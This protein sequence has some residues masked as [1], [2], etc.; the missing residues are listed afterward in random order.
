[1]WCFCFSAGSGGGW[2]LESVSLFF[3][4]LFHHHFGYFQCPDF[5]RF[6]YLFFM[7]SLSLF[8]ADPAIS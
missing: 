5:L 2:L 8:L 1:M 4:T 3:S 7:T 6:D